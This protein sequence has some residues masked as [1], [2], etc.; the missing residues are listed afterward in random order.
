MQ[1][2]V[3]LRPTA[4]Q[5]ENQNCFF[6][7]KNVVKDSVGANTSSPR[8]LLPVHLLCVTAKWINFNLIKR[9]FY[10]LRILVRNMEKFLMNK[11]VNYDSPGHVSIGQVI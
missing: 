1:K 3:C 6:G 9:F 10:P 5:I 7:N 4:L 8:I 2:L 11:A